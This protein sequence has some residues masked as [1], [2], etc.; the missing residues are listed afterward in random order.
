VPLAHAHLRPRDRSGSVAYGGA[1]GRFGPSPQPPDA[2]EYGGGGD[3]GAGG[4]AR[5]LAAPPQQP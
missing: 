1:A 2:D 5:S 4:S 3:E